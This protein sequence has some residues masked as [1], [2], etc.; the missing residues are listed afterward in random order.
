MP[1]REVSLKCRPL[2]LSKYP[3]PDKKKKKKSVKR[4]PF[5][6]VH[7]GVCLWLEQP[8]ACTVY[9]KCVRDSNGDDEDDDVTPSRLPKMPLEDAKRLKCLHALRALYPSELQ[10]DM[11]SCAIE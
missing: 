4:N 11:I 10:Y 2:S 6:P 9:G 3:C 1:K 5:T 7:V 8:L